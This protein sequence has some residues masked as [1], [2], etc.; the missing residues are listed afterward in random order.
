MCNGVSYQ[1]SL[2]DGFSFFLMIRRPPRSTL[3]PYT[4]L[5]RSTQVIA[6]RIPN[7]DAVGSYPWQSSRTN[8]VAIENDTSFTFFSALPANL[9]TV[10]RNKIDGQTPPAPAITG[11]SPSSGAA[12]TSVVI[13]G[14]NLVFATNVTFNGTSASFSIDSTAQITAAVPAGAT[15][16]LIRV[17]TL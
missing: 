11:F 16:G 4:T 2:H 14:T 17:Q 10:L 9:A 12:G 13:T 3:F 7:I 1:P 8:V 5:F 15:S 6:L